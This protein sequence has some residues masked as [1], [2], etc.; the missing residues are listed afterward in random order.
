MPREKKNRDAVADLFQL[1]TVYLGATPNEDSCA[2]AMQ[3]LQMGINNIDDTVTMSNFQNHWSKF[4]VALSEHAEAS[5][6][7]LNELQIEQR[8]AKIIGPKKS[9]RR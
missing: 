8:I 5:S 7:R 1:I 6:Y 2:Q 9:A 3:W 4:K